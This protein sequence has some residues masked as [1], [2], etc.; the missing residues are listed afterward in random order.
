MQKVLR[1]SV[2]ALLVVLEMMIRERKSRI[3]MYQGSSLT[4]GWGNMRP[5]WWRSVWRG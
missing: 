2:R 3:V 1:A 4:S 5:V